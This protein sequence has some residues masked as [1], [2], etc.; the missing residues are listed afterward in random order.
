MAESDLGKEIWM[1]VTYGFFD[2]IGV[3]F[4]TKE[5]AFISMLRDVKRLKCAGWTVSSKSDDMVR[6]VKSSIGEDLNI[7]IQR[8]TLR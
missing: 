7:Y 1:K 5:R 6:L 3:P 8:A 2:G 4:C